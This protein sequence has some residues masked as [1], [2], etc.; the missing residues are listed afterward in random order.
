MFVVAVAVAVVVLAP[1]S[2]VANKIRM[3]VDVGQKQ[4][5]F[6]EVRQDFV[7]VACHN[8]IVAHLSFDNKANAT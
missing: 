2:N 3:A 1:T 8:K 4:Q 7:L 6:V 5:P